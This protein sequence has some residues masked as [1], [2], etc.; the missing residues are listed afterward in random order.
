MTTS[1]GVFTGTILPRNETA[2]DHH[3]ILKLSTSHDI[4]VDV[5]IIQAVEERGSRDAH[6]HHWHHWRDYQPGD[7]R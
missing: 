2:D 6:N 3:I 7:L 5:D 1:D 4:G